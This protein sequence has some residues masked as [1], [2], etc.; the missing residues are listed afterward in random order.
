MTLRSTDVTVPSVPRV[1]T[2][3]DDLQVG[4][5]VA[6][7]TRYP[8]AN[9]DGR[10]ERLAAHEDV[11]DYGQKI[12]DGYLV[13]ILAD[14]PP[15]PVDEAYIKGW[16]EGWAALSGEFEKQRRDPSYPIGQD[17]VKP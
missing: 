6:W 13:F 3:L 5:A 9:M 16:H 7:M 2:S 4:Q 12:R 11:R 17:V 1:A 10:V 8:A 15:D 14:P